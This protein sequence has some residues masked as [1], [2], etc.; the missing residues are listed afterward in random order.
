[1]TRYGSDLL[2]SQV[3]TSILSRLSEDDLIALLNNYQ[4]RTKLQKAI[5]EV[6]EKLNAVN[7][8]PSKRTMRRWIEHYLLHGETPTASRKWI[9]R[10]ST[11]LK[12]NHTDVAHVLDI[13]N[14]DPALFL[15]EIQEILAIRTDKLFSISSIYQTLIENN[16]SLK[17]AYEKSCQ[18]DEDERADWMALMIELGPDASRQMIFID[19]THKGRKASR[20][21][22]HWAVKGKNQPFI[23]AAYYGG[24]D[25]R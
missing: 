20:R 18:R 15:D 17:V 19:E 5:D 3:I 4:T 13:V 12:W 10:P 24:L 25:N 16:Y 8:G 22:R 14:E 11:N 9:R 21:R 23:E 1:M 2:E 7:V 6:H